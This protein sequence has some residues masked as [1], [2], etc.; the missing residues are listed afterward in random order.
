MSDE[1]EI[2]FGAEPERGDE[3]PRAP[4]WPTDEEWIRARERD[5]ELK[6]LIRQWNE[7]QKQ[8]KGLGA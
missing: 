8:R 1:Y 7:L 4:L 2:D 3:P 5:E 6:A